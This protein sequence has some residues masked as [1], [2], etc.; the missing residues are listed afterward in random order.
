M[1]FYL[2][3]LVET[4]EL[5]KANYKNVFTG[6]ALRAI[7]VYEEQARKLTENVKIYSRSFWVAVAVA[8]ITVVQAGLIK[9]PPFL[10]FSPKEGG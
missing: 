10:D 5:K 7:E 2:E 4:G 3:C 6:H 8:A 9:L 1:E